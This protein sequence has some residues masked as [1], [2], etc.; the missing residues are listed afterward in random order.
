MARRSPMLMFQACQQGATREVEQLGLEPVSTW[1]T[2]T[3]VRD[4]ACNP[5]VPTDFPEQHLA[6]TDLGQKREKV[7]SEAVNGFVYIWH[8]SEFIEKE[9]E[10]HFNVMQYILKYIHSFLGSYVFYRNLRVCVCVCAHL[11]G[12]TFSHLGYIL[13]HTEI[14]SLHFF[15]GII[16]F[17]HIM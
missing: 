2:S 3:A 17:P 12:F 7:G 6:L 9:L 14:F 16:Q 11:Y 5:T 8:F 15:Q 10:N 1:N 4:L 13:V